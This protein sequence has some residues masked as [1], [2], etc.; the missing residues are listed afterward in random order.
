MQCIRILFLNDICISV[1]SFC[2]VGRSSVPLGSLI[3]CFL[4]SGSLQHFRL[5]QFP[6]RA[7]S[8]TVPFILSTS[9]S[10]VSISVL[11]CKCGLT[12]RYPASGVLRHCLQRHGNPTDVAICR[13]KTLASMSCLP[14]GFLPRWKRARRIRVGRLRRCRLRARECVACRCSVSAKVWTKLRSASVARS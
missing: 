2:P 10:L 14:D 1:G 4:N 6:D 3:T 12:I 7:L 11:K 8:V 5:A 13:W 9:E